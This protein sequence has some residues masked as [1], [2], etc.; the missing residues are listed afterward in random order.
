MYS[1]IA[2]LLLTNALTAQVTSAI[3]ST[4]IE[5][6]EQITY[7]IQVETDTTNLVVFPEGQTFSPLEMIESYAID[8]LKKNDK[9]NLVK[10]YGLTQF[11]SGA[12]TIPRQKIIVGNKTFFTDSLKVEV[13]NVVVDTTKQGLYDIKPIIEVKKKGGNWWKYVLLTL[14]IV[15]LVGGIL[16]WFIWRKKPLSEEEQIA[17][18][19]PYDRAKLALKKLDESHYLEH[20][21]LKSYYSELT[22]IIR[23]YL[24]EKV[25]DHSL[26]STTDELISKLRL[27]KDGNQID[28]S[29]ETIKNIES[30]LKRADLVKFAKSAPDIELA[31][32]DRNTIDTEIDHV[33]EVLPEPSEEEKLLDEKYREELERK[34]KRK[35]IIVTVAISLFL[36]MA[37][38][39][40]FSIKYGFGYVKDTIIGHDSKELLEGDWVTSDYGIP[41]VSISTPRVLKRFELP[42]PEEAK[43]KVKMTSFMYGTLLDVFSILVNTAT[44]PS[45]GENDNKIDLEQ[46]SENSIKGME[47]QGAENIT[48][49][50]EKFNTPNGAE[51]LKTYGTLNIVDPISNVTK[52]GNYVLLLFTSENVLQ[53]IIVTYPDDDTY[54]D[55][56]VERI[57]NS[58]ELKKEED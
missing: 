53:Q 44:Y 54:A 10:K 8:T 23:K 22:L 48:V 57:V 56:V 27:L 5:I 32:L 29:K 4:S 9:Y 45:S 30:I 15:A 41:P 2:F 52:G 11:D 24:D 37:T 14:L 35:K 1:T 25:Y 7:K 36:L 38:I 21:E 49:L 51:G 6:G 31:E 3:D 26:E 47:S 58:V 42:I 50:R 40:G 17:L 43:G 13:N 46:V 12:Y 39:G 33:K 18:L 19:P 28:L 16:W 34:K 55:Q 20:E